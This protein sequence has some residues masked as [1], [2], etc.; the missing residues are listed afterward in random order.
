MSRER[1][2]EERVEE[3]VRRYEEERLMR[4]KRSEDSEVIEEV[5]DRFTREA[6]YELMRRGIIDEIYGVVK[7]GKEARIYW[8]IDP[9]KRELAI[10]IYYIVSAEFRQGMLKYIKNDYRFKGVKTTPRSIIYAWAQKEFKNL[11]AAHEV[12]VRVPEPFE[13]KWNILV[14]GFVGEEGEPAP[15]LH[16]VHLDKPKAVYKRLLEEVKSLYTKAGIV[17]GDL[18]EYNVMFWREEPVLIDISQAVPTN[19]PLAEELLLRD[20]SNLNRYFSSLGVMVTDINKVYKGI[21]GGDK[22]L[23]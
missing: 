16:D 14:M 19:H 10:K 3:R 5:F 12:G 21:A 9:Q 20:I 17:H 13:V 2:V 1:G 7:A 18:S 4:T 23:R 22:G 11:K 15:L 8:G 6:L